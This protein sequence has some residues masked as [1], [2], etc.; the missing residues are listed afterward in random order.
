MKKIE[1]K[2][3]QEKEFLKNVSELS[4]KMAMLKADLDVEMATFWQAFKKRNGDGNYKLIPN[5]G[6]V[7]EYEPHE[8]PPK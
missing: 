1:L 4:Y 3:E 5:K 6:E 2:T 8:N 7:W